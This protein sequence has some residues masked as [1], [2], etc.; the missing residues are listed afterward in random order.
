MAHFDSRIDAEALECVCR[1]L[2]STSRALLTVCRDMLS[3]FYPT[4]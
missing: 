3:G 4:R 2:L 1:A